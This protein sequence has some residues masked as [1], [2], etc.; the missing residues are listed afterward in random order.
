MNALKENRKK[1]Q[2]PHMAAEARFRSVLLG[3]PGEFWSAV[4]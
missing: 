4:P 3:K 1:K 2:K